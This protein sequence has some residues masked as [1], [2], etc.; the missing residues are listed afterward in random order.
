[1]CCMGMLCVNAPFLATFL[2]VA[3]PCNLTCLQPLPSPFHRQSSHGP[4]PRS[5]H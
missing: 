1:M 2:A 5:H 4:H 3:F